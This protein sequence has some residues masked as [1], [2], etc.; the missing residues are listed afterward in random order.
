MSWYDDLF[1]NKIFDTIG[2][3][4]S[5]DSKLGSS[6]ISGGLG[7][8]NSSQQNKYLNAQI[9][10]LNSANEASSSSYDDYVDYLNTLAQWQAANGSDSDGRSYPY[11][12]YLK[13]A[14]EDMQPY[15]KM[16]L[17]QTKKMTKAY[18]KAM[19]ELADLDTSYDIAPSYSTDTGIGKYLNKD[20]E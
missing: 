20:K 6:L 17:K 1:D 19:N 3:W 5:K 4:F 8:Y 13:Q 16:A 7:L 15:K 18:N 12:S 2:N 10:A 11:I 9:D 14:I